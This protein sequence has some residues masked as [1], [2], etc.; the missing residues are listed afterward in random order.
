MNAVSPGAI[1][2]PFYSKIGLPEAALSAALTD[3]VQR[4]A[5]L[6]EEIPELAELD[7]N[8][9]MAMASGC[10]V[11]DARI[12]LARPAASQRLKSW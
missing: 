10:V 3:L 7:L 6:G 8:P 11:V 5:R 12:R 9:V 2:T 1:A 4:L